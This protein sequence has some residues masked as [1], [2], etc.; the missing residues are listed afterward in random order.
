MAH[1]NNALKKLTR[2]QASSYLIIKLTVV[3]RCAV[4][5]DPVTLT[6][7]ALGP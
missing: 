5:N 1:G 7:Y 2:S 4:P 3:V 6:M